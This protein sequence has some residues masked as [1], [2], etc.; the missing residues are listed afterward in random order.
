MSTRD[1]TAKLLYPHSPLKRT[2]FRAGFDSAVIAGCPYSLDAPAL[3][4]AWNLGHM[5]MI[6]LLEKEEKSV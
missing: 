4:E 3:V 5:A 6:K 1:Q 2:A